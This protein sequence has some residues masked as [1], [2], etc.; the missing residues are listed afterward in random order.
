MNATLVRPRGCENRTRISG[1]ARSRWSRIGGGGG[2]GRGGMIPP[3]RE[4]PGEH[5]PAPDTPYSVKTLRYSCLDIV[6]PHFQHRHY[7]KHVAEAD[8]SN[9]GLGGSA[10]TEGGRGLRTFRSSTHPGSISPTDRSTGQPTDRPTHPLPHHF[11][12]WCPLES[13]YLAGRELRHRRRTRGT[14][15]RSSYLNYAIQVLSVI[16]VPLKIK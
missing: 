12:P 15:R 10:A 16:S 8:K 9:N 3:K 1:S 13:T 2:G 5:E 6:K 4:A 7:V 11:P 14:C